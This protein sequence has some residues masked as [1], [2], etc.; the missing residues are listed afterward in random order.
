M[1]SE[2]V[3]VDLIFEK[4]PNLAYWCRPRIS[5]TAL[6]PSTPA[7]GRVWHSRLT[8]RAWPTLCDPLPRQ[9]LSGDRVATTFPIYAALAVYSL[10]RIL[11]F[12]VN[13]EVYSFPLV[14]PGSIQR[15][16]ASRA[17]WGYL[18]HQPT[19]G[20]RRRTVEEVLRL[21]EIDE[22]NANRSEAV[23]ARLTPGVWEYFQ[24]WS[25]PLL[26]AP[27]PRRRPVIAYPVGPEGRCGNTDIDEDV[28]ELGDFVVP[29]QQPLAGNGEVFLPRKPTFL[30]HLSFARRRRSLMPP[31]TGLTLTPT[32]RSRRA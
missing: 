12:E 16:G 22:L 15:G 28:V 7:P 8:C 24:S 4:A 10:V 18:S 5:E 32:T 31:R 27:P 11:E 6:F 19:P 3:I 30:V 9:H 26:P 21:S 1:E 23:Q 20:G 2:E 17:P 13:F 29:G 25:T 14:D